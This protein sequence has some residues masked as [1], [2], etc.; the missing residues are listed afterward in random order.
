MSAKKDTT[1]QKGRHTKTQ[2]FESKPQQILTN[3]S[4]HRDN[5]HTA[6]YDRTERNR[7]A[8][9]VTRQIVVRR[10]GSRWTLERRALDPE[11]SGKAVQFVGAVSQ[12]MA[13]HEAGPVPDRGIDIDRHAKVRCFFWAR[14]PV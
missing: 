2:R 5:F 13:P 10:R 8:A 3:P 12:Q 6:A 7:A 11:Q 4:P 14:R 9:L 1:S